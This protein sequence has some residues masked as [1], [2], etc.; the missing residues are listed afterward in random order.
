M[1]DAD[2]RKRAEQEQVNGTHYPW[3]KFP[4]QT[5]PCCSSIRFAIFWP[6]SSNCLCI[7]ACHATLG[8]RWTVVVALVALK[9]KRMTIAAGIFVTILVGAN[10]HA[11]G[12]PVLGAQ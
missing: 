4:S 10:S 6:C 1:A 2:G 8:G 11:K 7:V 9:S 5:L 12:A 3:L